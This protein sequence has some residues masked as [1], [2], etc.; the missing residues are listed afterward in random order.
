MRNVGPLAW[1]G[2]AAL[3]VGLAS[4]APAESTEAPSE[5]STA[6]VEQAVTGHAPEKIP[7]AT[8]LRWNEIML[9]ANAIDTTR[10]V[11]DQ[12]G[13]TRTSRAFAIV[14]IAVFDALNAI[15]GG[16]RSYTGLADAKEP[17]SASAAIAQ[18]G[19]DTLVS[20]YPSQA[21]RFDLLLAAD[22]LRIPSSK[23]KQNGIELGKQ[24]AAAILALRANDGSQK[25]DPVVGVNFFP[26]DQ[27]GYWRPDPISKDPLAVGAYW[28]EV[29]PFALRSADQFPIPPPPPLP[30]VEYARAYN[31]MKRLGGDGMTT[32][33]IR[34][35]EQT[36]IGIYWAYDGTP[37]LGQPP[38][39]LN[40]IATVIAKQKGTV[41]IELAR[42]FALLNVALADAAITCWDEKYDVQFWRPITGIREAD[43]GTGP[44]GKGDGN[45]LTKGDPRWTPLGSPASNTQGKPNFTPPFPSYTSGHA[46]FAGSFFETLRRFYKTDAIRFTFVSDEFNGRTRDNHGH[47]RPRIPRTFDSLSQAEDEQGQSRLYL[48]VH[49][50]FDKVYGDRNGRSVGDYVFDHVF[51]PERPERCD[52]TRE[53]RPVRSK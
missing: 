6:D 7:D 33:T 40:Q 11:E 23:A 38:R 46:T 48:G 52:L 49:W 27:P 41:G 29:T 47:V 51:L 26:S 1:A 14:E 4:C 18:A 5:E 13:A 16:Y 9:E 3:V 34:T 21:R 32:P 53:D 39:M 22:L 24:A 44:T 36:M 31:E 37:L 15:D 12:L 28:G 17:T 20:L 45:P 30:S 10:T 8:I 25:P 50:T 2:L 35:P 19:H 43:P 42:L